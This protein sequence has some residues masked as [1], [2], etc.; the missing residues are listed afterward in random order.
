M[1]PD[2]SA[3]V[4]SDPLLRGNTSIRGGDIWPLDRLEECA[5]KYISHGRAL[6][7]LEPYERTANIWSFAVL[8][9]LVDW[10]FALEIVGAGFD[11]GHLNR[12]RTVPHERFE[13]DTFGKEPRVTKH[14]PF[15][16]D[17]YAE[18]LRTHDVRRAPGDGKPL[19][20]TTLHAILRSLHQVS[21]MDF[22]APFVLSGAV[23]Q[24]GER[25]VF[26]DIYQESQR[27]R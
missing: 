1:E 20:H 14:A 12:G 27:N 4:R 24:P 8:G 17:R 23:L 10:G 2:R 13:G 22:A 25:L 18:D 21:E 5:N 9:G 26:W 7:L 16:H 15:D 11:T 6:I 3:L 19:P